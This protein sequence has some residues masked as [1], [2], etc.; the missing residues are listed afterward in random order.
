M[1]NIRYVL[2]VSDNTE[3]KYYK[4]SLQ[5]CLAKEYNFVYR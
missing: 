4:E 5:P 2:G 1:K 3:I